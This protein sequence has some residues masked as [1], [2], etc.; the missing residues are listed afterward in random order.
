MPMR[1]GGSAKGIPLKTHVYVQSS[2]LGVPEICAIQC[3]AILKALTV[4]RP[5]VRY[6]IVHNRLQ[7]WTLPLLLPVRLVDW[8]MASTLKLLP[9]PGL[10]VAPKAPSNTAVKAD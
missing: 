2:S 7:R 3:R 10:T 6:A 4:K 9:Q 5:S 8:L 1:A